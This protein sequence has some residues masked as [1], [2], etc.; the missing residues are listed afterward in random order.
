MKE[1]LA[2]HG[3]VAILAVVTLVLY[4]SSNVDKLEFAI[5]ICPEHHPVVML[6]LVSVLS[7]I[8]YIFYTVVHDLVGLRLVY[9]LVFKNFSS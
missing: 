5:L 8:L 4:P 1:G 7:W 2:F 3:L 9:M 6:I